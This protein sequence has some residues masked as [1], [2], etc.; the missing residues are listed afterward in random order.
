M[1][2]PLKIW[3]IAMNDHTPTTSQHISQCQQW[4]MS[5][6]DKIPIKFLPVL[7][8]NSCPLAAPL[9]SPYK[10]PSWV[11]FFFFFFSIDW[12]R[13]LEWNSGS[14]LIALEDQFPQRQQKEYG[15]NSSPEAEKETVLTLN[16]PYIHYECN[17]SHNWQW[18]SKLFF[19]F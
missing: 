1:L 15:T 17:I 13:G 8:P 16:K 3:E 2:S 18:E 10:E 5:T 14:L 19:F 9:F 12:H 4:E 11:M 6:A 7:F